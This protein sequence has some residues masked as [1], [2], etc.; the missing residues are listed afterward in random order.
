MKVQD[1]DW[2]ERHGAGPGLLSPQDWRQVNMIA[3]TFHKDRLL[4]VSGLS[5]SSRVGD[6]T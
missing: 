3:M 5:F 6:L 4:F 1:K 2:P